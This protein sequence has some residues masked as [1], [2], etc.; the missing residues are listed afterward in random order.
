MIRPAIIGLALVA[1]LGTLFAAPSVEPTNSSGFRGPNS[2]SGERNMLVPQNQP[3]FE[4]LE[5]AE[6]F[7]NRGSHDKALEAALRADSLLEKS[8]Q[9]RSGIRVQSQ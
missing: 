9:S 4:A 6:E 3:A 1:M 7:L 5:Q 2:V 8:P